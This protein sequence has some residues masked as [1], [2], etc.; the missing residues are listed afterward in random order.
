MSKLHTENTEEIHFKVSLY[1]RQP[2]KQFFFY[3]ELTFY[4]RI[5]SEKNAASST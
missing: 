4:F 5:I 3:Q 1:L 2:Q